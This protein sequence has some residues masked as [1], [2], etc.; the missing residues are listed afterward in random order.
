MKHL[1][2]FTALFFSFYTIAQK[3]TIRGKVIEDDNGLSVIGANVVIT[4]PLTGVS[5]DLDGE[6]SIDIVAGTYE[7]Q[8]SFISFQ[9]VIIKDVVVKEGEVTLLGNIRLKSSALELS[10]VVV[11]ATATRKSEAALNTMKKKSATMLDGISAQKMALIGDGSAIEAAQRVTGV[12]IEGGKYIYVRGLGDRY[13]KVTLNKMD[14]PGLDPDKNS[15]QMDIF[16]TNLID[17][18]VVSKNFTAD[19][20][21]DFT[22]GLINIE[23]K[24]FP[25]EKIMSASVGV[26]FN[27]DMHFNED[28]L[29]YE[30]GKTDFLGFDDGSRELPNRARQGDFPSLFQ[31]PEENQE[32]RDLTQ[33]FN[34]ELAATNQTSFLDYSAGFTIGDQININKSKENNSNKLGYIFS[35]TYKSEQRHYDNVTYSEYQRAIDVTNNELLYSDLQEGTLS[36]QNNLIGI[37]GGLAYKTKYSK[38]RLTT[39]LLQ[40]GESRAAKLLLN[41]NTSAVGRSGYV[42]KSDNL[43]YSERRLINF[44]LDGNHVFE[45]DKSWEVEWG[46]SPTISSADDPDVRKTPFTF[47]VDTSFQAGNAGLPQRIWRELS[48]ISLSSKIDITKSYKLFDEDAKLKFG[49]SSNYKER[50]YSILEYSIQFTSGQNWINNDPNEV[51]KPENIFPNTPNGSYLVDKNNNPNPNAYLANSLTSAVYVSNEFALSPNFKSIIGLRVENFVQRHTG[52]DQAFASGNGGNNLDNEIVLEST[53]LF[54]TANFIYTVAE[55]QNLRFGYARTIARP[56]FKELSF[57]QILDPITSRTFNGSL[58]EYPGSNWFGDLKQTDID[59]IDIRWEKFMSN[60]QIFSASFFY[61]QFE[62]PIELVRIPLVNTG[63]EYQARNVG[64]GRLYGFELEATKSLD[65]LGEKFEKLSLSGNIT[66]VESVIEMTEGEFG[67]REDN[68]REGESI[69]NER[70]MAGQAP[71]VVNFGVT[72][73]NLDKGINAGIFYNVKGKT[74]LIVGTGF[75]PDIYQ[76]PFHSLNLGISK[77]LGENQRT[78]V[79]LKVSNILD[80]ARE[81]FFESFGAADQIYSQFFPG[82]SV[83]LGINYKF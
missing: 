65:F 10:E 67:G 44:L 52:R 24:S 49:L 37:L 26:S 33:S 77:K 56:S 4:D 27:P 11:T 22:G 79:D 68:K 18:I 78:E 2:F 9:K 45:N 36:S 29:T 55:E 48:E 21:A 69:E 70:E 51:L 19:L 71:Y 60:G 20:P 7:V 58:F 63:F 46:I 13:S 23:T 61:K 43:E 35:L 31:S 15:L 83:S 76:Q 40:N 39:L 80:D 16:P 3:G 57:A 41:E 6:F 32:L 54:P 64:Q 42:G 12:S 25:D 14:I 1:L 81:E 47:A 8:V 59:N 82:T 17:N 72:Y 74:L 75:V 5:T 53:D 28:Y 50:D 34:P 73:S 66:I 30:G 62:N 38:I